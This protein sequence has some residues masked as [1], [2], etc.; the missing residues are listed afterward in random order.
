M[1][2]SGPNNPV[3]IAIGDKITYI[4][5]FESRLAVANGFD[6]DLDDLKTAVHNYI[7]YYTYRRVV[8]QP[9]PGKNEKRSEQIGCCRRT[10]AHS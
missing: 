2:G 8:M 10:G 7:G 6:V 1:L 4:S 9:T 3:T 5:N